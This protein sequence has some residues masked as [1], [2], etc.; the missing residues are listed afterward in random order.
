ML[1]EHKNDILKSKDVL[2]KIRGS[3]TYFNQ[4][5]MDIYIIKLRKYLKEDQ[6]IE[7]VNVDRNSLRLIAS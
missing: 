3:N 4:R 5:S 1:C 7:I 6:T 2:N